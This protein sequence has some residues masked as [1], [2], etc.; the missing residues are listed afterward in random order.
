M[1][2]TWEYWQENQVEGE[3]IDLNHY[4]AIGTMAEALSRH[5]EETYLE[6]ATPERKLIA[7]KMFKALTDRGSDA[8]GVRSPRRLEEICALT[9][10]SPAGVLS[11]VVVSRRPG[12]SYL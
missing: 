7:E 2:R 5:A 10:A 12:R 8:R 11:G 4:E 6:L 3:P 1:M 9:G